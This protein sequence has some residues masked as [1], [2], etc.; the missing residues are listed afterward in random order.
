MT[1]LPPAPA[2]RLLG[3]G[4]AGALVRRA[5]RPVGPPCRTLPEPGG[6]GPRRGRGVGMHG[7]G[8]PGDGGVGQGSGVRLCGGAVGRRVCWVRC[9]P[10]RCAMV[11]AGFRGGL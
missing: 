3:R 7:A 1:A 2:A 10:V 4:A 8:V 6:L 5:S 9:R 11:R